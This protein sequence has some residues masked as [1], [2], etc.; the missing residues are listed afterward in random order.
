MTKKK[1]L[2]MILVVAAIFF[3]L[4]AVKHSRKKVGKV[5]LGPSSTS[6][7]PALG[8]LQ[9]KDAPEWFRFFGTAQDDEIWD[10]VEYNNFLYAIGTKRKNTSRDKVVLLKFD[11]QGKLVWEKTWDGGGY[12]EGYHLAVH[13]GYLYAGGRT[14]KPNVDALI[15]K[16]DLDGN[17]LWS[18]T[19]DGK[20]KKYEEVDGFAFAGGYL[21]VAVPSGPLFGGQDVV[22][23][24]YDL[25]G[26][27][28]WEKY[29][30]SGRN[31]MVNG[32][33]TDGQYLYLAV[34][35]PGAVFQK[36]NDAFLQK[37]DL[38]GN[39][40]WS[41]EWGGDDYDDPLGIG[42][43][44]KY[45]YLVGLTKSF[46]KNGQVFALKFDKTTGEL[47]WDKVWGGKQSEVSRSIIIKNGYS[48]IAGGT[49]SYGE[50][51]EDVFLLILDPSGRL[52]SDYFWGGKADDRAKNFILTSE[53]FYLVGVT[54][55]Y[56]S[57]KEDGFLLKWSFRK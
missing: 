53:G 21:Y 54:S 47:L 8:E 7:L 22:I 41:K 40:I 19:W 12:D 30:D 13:Q 31:D 42:L 33:L 36:N 20:K 4:S 5:P 37:Y 1:V 23:L 3:A 17:L 25:Q 10:A 48:Y 2:L 55:S 28:I 34:R 50:G 51:G 44:G 56:G 15:L 26:N 52:L 24:K 38:N 27:L 49:K 11:K 9:P 46:G 43:E 45:V 16:Y 18:R 35:S 29:W 14:G 57:G 32:I 39:L 6:S